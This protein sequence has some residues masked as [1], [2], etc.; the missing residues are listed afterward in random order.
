MYFAYVF[1]YPYFI[2]KYDN[3]HPVC[4]CVQ[5]DYHFVRGE[6]TYDEFYAGDG[7]TQLV[8]GKCSGKCDI[9]HKVLFH[10]L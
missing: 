3:S 7:E 4:V 1:V 9:E 6:P 2:Q 5:A 8:I 10:M